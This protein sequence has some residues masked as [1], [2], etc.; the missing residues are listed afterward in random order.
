ML[1]RQTRLACLALGVIASSSGCDSMTK[2][3]VR[4]K[5][6]AD[7]LATLDP[8]VV[9]KD[10]VENPAAPKLFKNNRLSGGLSDQAR[11]IE[12]DFGIH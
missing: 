9:T 2:R 10:P 4:I 12:K 8:P 1:G 3:H 6:S 7:E 5:S 11:D